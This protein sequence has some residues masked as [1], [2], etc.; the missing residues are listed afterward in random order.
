MMELRWYRIIGV[1]GMCLHINIVAVK[2]YTY[3]S[4]LLFAGRKLEMHGKA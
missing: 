2:L 4:G 3:I 1:A